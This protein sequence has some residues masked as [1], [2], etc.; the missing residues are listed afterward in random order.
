MTTISPDLDTIRQAQ[1]RI[2]TIVHRTL[3]ERSRW[4][5][6]TNREVF[7]KFECLQPTGS[8]KLRGAASKMTKLAREGVREVLTVSAGNHGLAVA[9]CAEALGLSAT[10]IVPTTAS[11]AKVSA[12]KEYKINLIQEGANYDEA[13]RAGRRMERDTGLAFVSPYNDVEVIAGQGTTALE[14]AEELDDVDSI[15]VS[16]GGGGLIAGVAVAAKAINPRIKVFG[17]E[18]SASPTMTAALDAGR[19]IEISEE[20][21]VADGLAGNIE[22]GSITF[23]IVQQLVDGIILVSESAIRE[24]LAGMARNEHMIVEGSAAAAIAA[25][26]DKRLDRGKVVAIV[27]GRNIS[28]ETFIEIVREAD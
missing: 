6:T 17:V 21:T 8:F 22:P 10:V 27:S 3:L 23:P 18:P 28:L 15:V 4:L 24:S 14:I 13:E 2:S 20:E 7:L 19:V 11:T 25:L 12:L 9:H 5:S 1:S 26:R 16:V